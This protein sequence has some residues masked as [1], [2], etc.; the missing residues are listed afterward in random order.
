VRIRAVS[1]AKR[2]TLP[3][4]R[5]QRSAQFCSIRTGLRADAGP[6]GDAVARRVPPWLWESRAIGY[7]KSSS[8]RVR[9]HPGAGVAVLLVPRGGAT[10]AKLVKESSDL[11]RTEAMSY[12]EKKDRFEAG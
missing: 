1:V 3:V 4:N 8:P 6:R 11:E 2:F 10:G 12:W 7:R 9:G 5:R